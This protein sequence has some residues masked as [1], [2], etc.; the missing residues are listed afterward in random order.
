MEDIIFNHYTL[1]IFPVKLKKSGQ[2]GGGELRRD[3]QARDK[4]AVPLPAVL[5]A[6]VAALVV[7]MGIGRFAYT[8]ILPLMQASE[9]FSESIAGLVAAANY[10]GYFLAALFAAFFSWEG[11]RINWLRVHLFLSLLTTGVMGWASGTVWWVLIR[12][13]SGWSS[14]VVFVLASSLVLECLAAERRNG[15]AGMFYSGV[16]LGIALSG[17]LV[18]ELASLFGWRGAWWGLMFV[19][20]VLSAWIW[21]G[22]RDEQAADLRAMG[23][24]PVIREPAVHQHADREN[25]NER[26]AKSRDSAYH[27]RLPS[28]SRTSRFRWLVAAYG[29]EG[30]G[31]IVSGTFLVAVVMDLPRMEQYGTLSWVLVGL[32]AAPSTLVWSWLAERRG[33]VHMLIWA[34]LLQAVGVV[35]PVLS[36][37]PVMVLLGAILFGGTFMGITTLAL[38]AG[39]LLCEHEGNRAVGQLTAAYGLGQIIGPAAAGMV[40]D[41]T[42]GYVF[43][44]LISSVVLL[45]GM[46]MLVA[47]RQR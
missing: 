1:W 23:R 24:D 32:A 7:V 18:P 6:G 17:L 39:R 44:L 28:V 19:G 25:I 41:W 36:S 43:P 42:G 40:A 30:L 21:Y 29:C 33:Y 20:A 26:D 45:S 37:H 5:L 34:Y 2:T 12:L 22:L 4:R 11:R 13:L 16:G 10:L 14:G 46:G 9:G 3:L 35:L 27:T 47:V 38:T 15:W 8:P 31:Y